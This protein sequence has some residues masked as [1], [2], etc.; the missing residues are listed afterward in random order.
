MLDQ[1]EKIRQQLARKERT[2]G[3][4][5]N[6]KNN[7]EKSLNNLDDFINR[8]YNRTMSPSYQLNNSKIN[9]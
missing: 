1:D 8:S 4:L 7:L 6:N 3:I 9:N 5:R 2:A